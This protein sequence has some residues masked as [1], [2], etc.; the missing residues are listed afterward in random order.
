MSCAAKISLFIFFRGH[1]LSVLLHSSFQLNISF[2]FNLTWGEKI[3]QILPFNL[4]CFSFYIHL[5]PYISRCFSPCGSTRKNFNFFYIRKGKRTRENFFIVFFCLDVLQWVL[6]GSQK[7]ILQIKCLVNQIILK[8]PGLANSWIWIQ[9][10]DLFLQIFLSSARWFLSC[11]IISTIL[12]EKIFHFFFLFLHPTQQSIKDTW[13][14]FSTRSLFVFFLRVLLNTGRQK[15]RGGRCVLDIMCVPLL[16]L[17][18]F[19]L[20]RIEFREF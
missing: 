8:T 2:H 11:C 4:S 17:L 1:T 18:R 7:N 6:W 13:F 20:H 3:I 5:L 19:F 15:E 12:Q 10:M 9:M 14:L 16:L